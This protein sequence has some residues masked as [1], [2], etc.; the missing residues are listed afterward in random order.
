M[1]FKS[2][3]GDQLSPQDSDSYHCGLVKFDGAVASGKP[4]G[5]FLSLTAEPLAQ[6]FRFVT[7]YVRKSSSL[8][9]LEPK[10]VRTINQ[11]YLEQSLSVEGPTTHLAGR[12]TL[13]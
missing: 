11:D 3:S 8:L 7:H 10:C 1:A 12:T 5:C 4:F 9:A 6:H 13:P 2:L